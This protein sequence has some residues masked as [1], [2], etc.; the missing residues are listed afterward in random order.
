MALAMV[1]LGARVSR[2]IL[3]SRFQRQQSAPHLLRMHVCRCMRRSSTPTPTQASASLSAEPRK[4]RRAR[5]VRPSRVPMACAVELHAFSPSPSH[6]ARMILLHNAHPTAAWQV[7][8][9]ESDLQ[10]IAGGHLLQD[11]GEPLKSPPV[12]KLDAAGTFAFPLPF[13]L[14]HPPTT[15]VYVC[16]CVCARVHARTHALSR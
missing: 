13:D 12:R 11:A 8:Q 4:A 15:Q 5:S 10:M 3:A 7:G 16:S 2:K 6:P 9:L 1:Y 14:I